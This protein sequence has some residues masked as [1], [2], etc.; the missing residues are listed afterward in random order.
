MSGVITRSGTLLTKRN[1]DNSYLEL[2]GGTNYLNGAYLRLDGKDNGDY[3]GRFTLATGN[4]SKNILLIGKT[5]GTLNW[6]GKPIVTTQDKS[7]TQNG[8]VKFNN[9]L[10]IQ[11]GLTEQ[12]DG[13]IVVTF[14]VPFTGQYT[15]AVTATLDGK[16]SSAAS[17]QARTNTTFS[18][19]PATGHA[20]A[21][22]RAAW[23][24]IGY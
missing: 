12:K 3:S 11:W 23:I 18:V 20:S 22:K 2:D 24:A 9:G 1:V 21:N 19:D 16:S 10:I 15:Y 4:G 6:N 14:P 5:D 7:L 17:V 8:Y 13:V